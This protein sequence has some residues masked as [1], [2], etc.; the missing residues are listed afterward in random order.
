MR[1]SLLDNA[2]FQIRTPDNQREEMTLSQVLARLATSNVVSFEA[3]QAHQEQ[4]WYS[5]LV[6]LG[7]LAAVH[8][9]AGTWPETPEEWRDVLLGLADGKEAAWCLVVEELAEPAF[10]QPPVQEDALED[11][12]YKNDVPTPDRLDVLVTSKNHDVKRTRITYPRPEHWIYALLTL[13]TMEGFLGRGNYGVIRMN[14]GFG[15]R[16]LVG[17]APDLSWGARFQ[18]DLTVLTNLREEI[19]GRYPCS[20]DG[21]KLLWLEPWDG[22]KGD[23]IKLK[24]CDPY[25]V[26]VCRRIR[27]KENSGGHIECWRANSKG[28]RVE[29]HDDL[30]GV[31]GDPWTPIDRSE[32]KALTLS[33]SGFTYRR[34]DE[35]LI[36]NEYRRPIALQFQDSEQ[37]GA[38]LIA[39]TLVRGQGKTEG[40]HY[41]V[42]PVPPEI[43]AIAMG[44]TGDWTD[45]AERSRSRI[46]VV[47]EVE[48]RVLRPAI[49]E[50]F[51]KS[52]DEDVERED[53][54]PWLDDFSEAVDDIFFESLWE[55][56]RKGLD[57]DE[58]N[59]QWD[60][61]LFDLAKDQFENAEKSVP[62]PTG[63]RWRAVSVAK[64]VLRGTCRKVLNN[65]FKSETPNSSTEQPSYASK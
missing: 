48:N 16:P 14:G 25:F 56:F 22:T 38:Y 44:E 34:I 6:Q 36:G 64:N 27:L 29:A 63:R 53:V 57:E 2:L 8:E 3:L 30:N 43:T 11:A 21:H 24:K 19:L 15:N 10:L 17:L 28:Q 62:I 54:Q 20:D 23:S 33:G 37:D 50:L 26:E 45:V 7:A 52:R 31:T 32:S 47:G 61:I 49:S 4:A 5:F 13:Q 39:R 35:I 46:Q 65:A 55:S 60:R 9:T 41:R 12:G 58:A 1:H 18:R 42:V 59:R 51:K 40:L